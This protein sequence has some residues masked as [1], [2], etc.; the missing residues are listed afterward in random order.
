[1]DDV[2]AKSVFGKIVTG[3]FERAMQSERCK[4]KE[5]RSVYRLFSEDDGKALEGL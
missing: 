1:M 3:V 2:G 5:Y 4:G